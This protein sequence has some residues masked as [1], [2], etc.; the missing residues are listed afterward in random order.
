MPIKEKTKGINESKRIQ[1][2]QGPK[3][4]STLLHLK[5]PPNNCQVS[6]PHEMQANAIVQ[7]NLLK[8]MVGWDHGGPLLSKEFQ[9]WYII[10]GYVLELYTRWF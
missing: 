9:W 6:C 1:E 10:L 8:Y 3:S 4:Q 5:S 7:E 2:K